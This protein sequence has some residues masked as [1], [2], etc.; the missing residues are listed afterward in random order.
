MGGEIR[1]VRRETPLGEGE[2]RQIQK[3]KNKVSD[4]TEGEECGLLVDSKT[5]IA[6][7]DVLENFILVDK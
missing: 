1:I 4:I 2:I 7:G 6:V 5:E 3:L